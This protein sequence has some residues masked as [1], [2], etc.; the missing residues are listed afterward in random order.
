MINPPSETEIAL[1]H[2]QICSALADPKRIHMLYVLKDGDR[3]VSELTRILG[4]PQSTISR[5]LRVLRDRGLVKATQQGTSVIYSL[6]DV[7]LIDAMD[8]LRL[9]LNQQLSHHSEIAAGINP[10]LNY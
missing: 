5:H 4:I 10:L 9:V 1:L 3:G 7:R 8:T 6:T 2:Q